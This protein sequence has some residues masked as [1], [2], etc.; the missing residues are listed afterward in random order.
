MYLAKHIKNFHFP[1]NICFI[2][3]HDDIAFTLGEGELISYT[4]DLVMPVSAKIWQETFKKARN[5]TRKIKTR[6]NVKYS[7]LALTKQNSWNFSLKSSNPPDNDNIKI[8]EGDC[9]EHKY[10]NCLKTIS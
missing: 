7:L 9:L 5:K 8:H 2:Y 6:L 3:V 4:D 1:K 10:C